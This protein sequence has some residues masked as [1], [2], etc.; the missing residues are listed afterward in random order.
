MPEDLA[1]RGYTP[2]DLRIPTLR[3]LLARFPD[4]PVNIELKTGPP[5]ASS[6]ARALADLLDEFDRT[7]DVVVAS[8]QD[9]VLYEFKLLAPDVHTAPSLVE[10]GGVMIVDADFVAD[11]HANGMAVHVWTINSE[12]QMRDLVAIGVDGIRTDRPSLLQ[13]VLDDAGV[14]FT[15]T[16]G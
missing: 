15:S 1:E 9:Q 8:F 11:A 6:M 7:D 10:F 4:V 13:R 16:G 12:Q 14:G 3:E 5:A 2:E